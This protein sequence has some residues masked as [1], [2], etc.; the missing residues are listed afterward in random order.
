MRL[1]GDIHG[2]FN[3]YKRIIKAAPA[4]IQVGDLGVG[5]RI[6]G[7][8]PRDGEFRPNPPYDTMCAQNALFIRGN[9][10]NPAVCRRH[11]RYIDDGHVVNDMMFI[12][13]AYSI[14]WEFRT[15]GYSWWRD[16]ELS[17]QQLNMLVTDYIRLKPRVMI[18]HDCPREVGEAIIMSMPNPVAGRQLIQTRTGQ[19]FQE[20]MNAH[21]PELWV[22]GHY[23]HS[24]DHVLRG[25]RF[26]CLAE[27]EYRDDLI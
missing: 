3:I 23:H 24:F 19:A 12:G 2:H 21:S 14:D 8:G 20:M 10:D 9:H 4:S 11:P 1:I 7:H 16:E 18:T 6:G 15:E 26:V 22:F 27:F 5:F 17:I 25:T 13:G